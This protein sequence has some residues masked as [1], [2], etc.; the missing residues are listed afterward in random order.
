MFARWFY[1]IRPAVAHKPLR[2][3]STK[4]DMVASFGLH[5]PN[6]HFTPFTFE[7]GPLGQ[8]ST[9][10]PTSFWKGIKTI[11][12]HGDPTLK[13]GLAVH[14]YAA[15][16]S[17][18]KQAFVNH[19]G[20]FLIIPVQGRLDIQTELGRM[21]VCPG[22]LCVIQAGLRFK[23]VLPDGPVH[24][25]I[26]EIFGAHYEL[27]ELGPIG[28]N[29]L[30]LPKDFEVPVASFDIDS[31]DWEVVLKLAG[32]LYHYSQNHT[33]FDVVAWHGNYSPYKYE[34]T[35][36]LALSSMKD[37]LDPSAYCILTAKSKI[38]GVSL[39]DFCAFTPKWVN[40]LDSFRPP[41]YHRTM[42]SE[43]MGMIYGTYAG[44]SK[45]LS[46]GALTCDNSFVAHGESY[47]A[48]KKAT[49]EALEPQF[50]GEG[51]LS[52]MFHMS[53][54]VA[55]SKFAM[56]RHA[57]TKPPPE[58]LWDD[59]QGDFLNHIPDINEKLFRA[60]RPLIEIPSA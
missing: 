41:Y 42:A 51:T 44:S 6:V 14:Q 5:N 26:Q 35:K 16:V 32:E 33:P 3:L 48:W 49:S 18:G 19:D 30:A 7:W 4:H 25:Y 36:I 53:S 38:T 9:S 60:G 58:S 52:F 11:A 57:Q 47:Q 21:M 39:S 27:P 28:S 22:E 40:S 29:G 59:L 8:A 24:G 43:M 2:P 15:N 23:V 10:D 20:D 50:Q 56:E 34:M 1:R 55:V 45:T 17:M 54:H 31:S 13:E 12:G 46:P 37:Q